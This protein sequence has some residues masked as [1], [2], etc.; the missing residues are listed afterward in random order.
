MAQQQ[1]SSPNMSKSDMKKAC[2]AQMQSS[3]SSPHQ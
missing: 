3:S 1:A 2:K